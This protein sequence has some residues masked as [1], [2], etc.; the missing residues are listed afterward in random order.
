MALVSGHGGWHPHDVIKYGK[1]TYEDKPPPRRGPDGWEVE[2]Q[3]VLHAEQRG[4][5]LIWFQKGWT[6]PSEI[7]RMVA[8]DAVVTR[9][10]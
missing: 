5:Q 4:I 8:E 1:F 10:I 7:V 2:T 3:A 9:E 6:G